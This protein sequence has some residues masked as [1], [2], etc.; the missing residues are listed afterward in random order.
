ML[1][2]GVAVLCGASLLCNALAA[3]W[4][5]GESAALWWL[6]TALALGSGFVKLAGAVYLERAWSHGLAAVVGCALLLDVCWSLGFAQMTREAASRPRADVVAAHA[7][8]KR[9]ATEKQTALAQVSLPEKPAAVLRAELAGL[10]D[11]GCN[12][13]RF[14]RYDRCKDV[15]RL[16]TAIAAADAHDK[17]QREHAEAAAALAAHGVPPSTDPLA[18]ALGNLLR[19]LVASATDEHA[20]LLFG[21]LM[22]A[23]FEL[24][25]ILALPHALKP[26]VEAPREPAAA[27]VAPP[28]VAPVPRAALPSGSIV[29]QLQAL[30]A[31]PLP[32]GVSATPSGGLAGSQRAIGAALG[33]NAA[34]LNAGLRA[35]AAAGQ[36]SVATTTRGTVV[37]FVSNVV[38]LR[39]T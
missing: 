20:K 19:T 26:P 5:A 17:A 10:D 22:V 35:A 38:A 4:L 13:D 7:E 27:H 31:G 14:K 25:P 2:L 18:A 24:A 12:E 8:L 29:A 37:E 23:L 36:L 6:F 33:L 30:A 21:L 3:Q 34:K 1:L 39:R 11:R 16:K 15:A 9:V 28:S 32:A